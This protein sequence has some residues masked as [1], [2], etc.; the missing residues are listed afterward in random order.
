[1]LLTPKPA[2]VLTHEQNVLW[3][4]IELRK[5][6]YTNPPSNTLP[7]KIIEAEGFYASDVIS[8]IEAV[9]PLGATRLIIRML[10]PIDLAYLGA[11]DAPWTYV[12]DIAPS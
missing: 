9:P 4:S 7:R 6:L 1:M 11:S 5:A 2:S 3:S 8:F 12:G 10:M